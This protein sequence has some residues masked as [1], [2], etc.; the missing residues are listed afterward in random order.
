[1]NMNMR[2]AGVWLL[3]AILAINV[4][5][6]LK[7]YSQENKSAESK[8]SVFKQI[9][10]MMEVLQQIRQNYVDE[11]KTTSD[12][13]FKGAIYGMMN[14]LDPFS[15]YLEGDI[16]EQ[17][18]EETEG[19]FGGIGI[20][21]DFKESFLIVVSPID[22]TPADKA[23]LK[24]GDMILKVNDEEVGDLGMDKTIKKMRG[25]PG[26]TVRITYMRDTFSEPREIELTRAVIPIHS[27][28]KAR[29][30]DDGIGYVRITQFMDK[31][32]EE[33]EAVLTEKFSGENVKALIIDLRN[34]PGGLLDSAVDI[35]SFFLPE[36]EFV[37]SVEGRRDTHVEN[38]K[39]GYK[40]RDIPLLLLV[41]QGSASAAEIMSG[42]LKVH[43]RAKLVGSKTFGKGSV[44]NI[45][46]LSN[47]DEI[48]LTVA[49]YFIQPKETEN[50]IRIHKKGLKP[51]TVV[52]YSKEELKE[53]EKKREQFAEEQ[54]NAEQTESERIAKAEAFRTDLE[55]NDKV[56]I[57]A[58]AILN[59]TYQEEKAEPDTSSTKQSTQKETDHD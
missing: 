40:F 28:T 35:C 22:G 37:V 46:P 25:K 52:Q 47:G 6:G 23:G 20:Q 18:K 56:L 14:T 9:D 39:G 55:L 33:L 30:F 51:D 4:I 27:V 11:D 24:T 44:Q 3:G 45:I 10:L 26:T 2:K 1:M 29:V 43:G 54:E 7:G 41:N 42:C 31:T 12:K 13:L 58:R 34:N 17:F 8:D 50:R 16:K 15:D 19:E 48:K 5:V 59:G 36:N 32:A 38:A 53:L 21:V 49:Y 57:A